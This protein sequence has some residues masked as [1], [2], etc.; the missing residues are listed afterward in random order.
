MASVYPGA[1]DTFALGDGPN[2][3]IGPDVEDLKDAVNKI[4]AELGVAP[5]GAAYATVRARLDAIQPAAPNT[6][7]IS[8]DS[9]LRTMNTDTITHNGLADVV[10]TIIREFQARG[11]FG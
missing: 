3:Y 7:T 5:S 1:L 2:E 8:N 9:T 4:E 10:A 11:M 6:W